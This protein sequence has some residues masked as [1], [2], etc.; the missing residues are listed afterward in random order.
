MGSVRTAAPGRRNRRAAGV[1]QEAL[2]QVLFAVPR[3][4]G[5]RRRLCRSAPASRGRAT[6][7]RASSRFGRRPTERSRPIRTSSTSSGAACPTPRCPPG[8]AFSDQEVSDLAY[9]IT[10]FSADFSNRRE[11]AQARAAPERAESHEGVDR[12]REEALRGDRLRQVPRHARSRRRT[13]GSNPDG[14]LGASDTPGGPRAELDLPRRIVP[15]GHLPD[16]EHGAQRH[17]HAVVP[18]GPHSPSNDGRSRTSSS[19]SR[20]ATGPATPTSSSPSTSRIRSTWPRG[21]RASHP[22]VWPAFRSSGR[23]WSPDARSILRRPP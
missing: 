11:C 20:G 10:T 22:R 3:R 19:R 2:P 16:D 15:R 13:F 1:G 5:R 18:R 7:R 14:R 17:A 21:P 8:P 23:S 9:F 4:Q 6:S 12:A